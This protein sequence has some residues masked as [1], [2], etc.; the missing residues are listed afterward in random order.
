MT[1]ITFLYSTLSF[2]PVSYPIRL[3]NPFASTSSRLSALDKFTPNVTLLICVFTRPRLIWRLQSLFRR[4]LK[5]STWFI[6][7]YFLFFFSFYSF[8]SSS[9]NS[10]IS[11][12]VICLI[13][14]LY[15][16]TSQYSSPNAWVFERFSSLKCKFLPFTRPSTSN[17]IPILYDT[18]NIPSWIIFPI[19]FWIASLT[20]F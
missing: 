3:G 20:T 14:S 11:F 15:L 9:F 2:H 1:C 17:L 18:I 6:T 13:L 5:E 19:A 10:F 8:F 4:Y 7:L 12:L 16:H